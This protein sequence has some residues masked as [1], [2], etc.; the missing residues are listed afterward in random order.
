MW[1]PS[2]ERD[3]LEVR[4]VPRKAAPKLQFQ[5]VPQMSSQQQDAIDREHRVV[6]GEQ[7]KYATNIE[8]CE[9]DRSVGL[10][11]AVKN[12]GDEETAEHEERRDTEAAPKLDP[13]RRVHM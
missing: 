8:R 7:T 10:F 12:P 2:E 11:L 3:L 13:I 5:V 1:L 9:A 6:R 4:Q